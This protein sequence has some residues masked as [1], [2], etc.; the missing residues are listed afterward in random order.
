[1]TVTGLLIGLFAVVG[2]PLIIRG[3]TFINKTI[4]EIE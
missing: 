3:I 1:M 2:I 4:K